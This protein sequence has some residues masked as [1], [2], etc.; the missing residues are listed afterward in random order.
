MEFISENPQDSEIAAISCGDG[1]F[2]ARCRSYGHAFTAVA[3][4]YG[5]AETSV[6]LI[7]GLYT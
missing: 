4:V 5:T 3:A 1:A 6:N 7:S 2:A